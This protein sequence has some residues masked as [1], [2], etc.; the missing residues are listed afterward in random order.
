[1]KKY[2]GKSV[3]EGIAIGKLRVYSGEQRIIEKRRTEDVDR[4]LGRFEDARASVALELSHL[5]QET[6]R[7]AGDQV[8]AIFQGHSLILQDEVV[9]DFIREMIRTQKVDAESAVAAAG[10]K[11]AGAFEQLDDPYFKER[12]ADVKDVKERV[13]RKL[14]GG[15]EEP[16]Q[17]VEEPVILAARELTPSQTVRMDPSKILGFVTELG[18]ANSH[19]AILSRAMG[20][21]ALT[22]LRFTEEMDGKLAVLDGFSGE[23]ILEPD[24]TTLAGYQEKQKGREERQKLF[25]ELRGKEDVTADGRRMDLF[26]NVGSLE[27]VKRALENDAR[28]IGLF[29]TEFLYLGKTDFPSEEEQFQAYKEALEQMEGKKVI[30]R[31]LDVGADKQTDYLQMEPEANPALGCRGIR[32]CLRRPDIFKTQLRALVRAS[33]Y[34]NLGILY[35]MIISVDEIRQIK[36]LVNEVKAELE[37]EGISYGT[38]EQGVMIETPAAVMISSALAKEV[39]FFSIGTNDLTQYT[40]AVDRQ[41][42]KLDDLFD[43]R[44]PAVM[45]LIR[46]TVKNGHAGGC[47]VGICGELGADPALTG[48]FLEM[49]VDEL[50]VTPA[51]VL[52]IRKIIRE[53]NK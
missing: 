43:P 10:E 37:E 46:M 27:E 19:V 34:G 45:D 14:R 31:T 48:T 17:E 51:S 49:G 25:A 44:H 29:R 30:I 7:K 38:F 4:E 3:S 41:D 12:S 42:A 28:G 16:D 40:L 15:S 47:R 2:Q 9:I 36:A 53:V 21:A 1:M 20:I 13:L 52:R 50:S 8:A 39:D 6:A 32:L 35:P 23:L 24:E 22:G 33:A 5:Y 18:S 11:F 26:A